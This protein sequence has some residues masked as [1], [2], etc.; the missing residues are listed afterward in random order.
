MNGKMK[1]C[2][3]VF[4]LLHNNRECYDFSY[5]FNIVGLIMLILM[6]TGLFYLMPELSGLFVNQLWPLARNLKVKIIKDGKY[7]IKSLLN[8]LYIII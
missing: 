4:I 6:V 2:T 1:V 5:L 3:S 7:L 8:R